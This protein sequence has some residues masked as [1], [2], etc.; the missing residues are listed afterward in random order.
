MFESEFA[1]AIGCA[2]YRPH[3]KDFNTIG[4]VGFIMDKLAATHKFDVILLDVSPSNSALNQISALSCD[5][6]LPPCM[7]SIYSC[8]SGVYGLLASVLPR[9][10][11]WLGKQAFISAVQWGPDWPTRPLN[12]SKLKWRLPR[13]APKLLPI[14]V[15]NYGVEVR[16]GSTQIQISFS[17]SQ[18]IYAI[19]HYVRSECPN[20]D[21]NQGA[22]S[23]EAVP[24]VPGPI[25]FEPNHGARVIPFAPSVPVSMPA[26]EGLGRP[27]VELQLAHFQ[28]FYNFDQAEG[29]VATRARFKATQR[30]QT[31]IG[32][33][34]LK[35]NE[36]F[37][38]EVAL[39]KERY[40]SL[41]SWVSELLA[42]KTAAALVG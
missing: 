42:T 19:I 1:D 27:F 20:V 22:P 3:E 9:E 25:K 36:D 35:A 26:S 37:K 17:A 11:G 33:D 32:P 18:F 12:L 6:I 34:P 8:G 38:K 23:A 30:Q 2:G 4:L 31:M 21:G 39:M 41:A 24:G 14:L 7:A 15:T 40:N 29:A 10:E 5:Y 28:Q 13:L 16:A